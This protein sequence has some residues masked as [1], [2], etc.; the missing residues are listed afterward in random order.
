MTTFNELTPVEKVKIFK[1]F[2]A[3]DS[4]LEEAQTNIRED[5]LNT[6]MAR[7]LPGVLLKSNV[8]VE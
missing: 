8:D 2:D 7:Q 4:K 6:A 3:L 1:E 5:I